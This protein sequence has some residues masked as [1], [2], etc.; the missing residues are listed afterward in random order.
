MNI[1]LIGMP[2][3]G[4]SF[5]GKKIALKLGY[6][7]VDIDEIIEKENGMS[8]QKLLDK[9][10]KEKFIEL[11]G[12]AVLNLE[13]EEKIISP[14]GSVIYSN[15]AM[16]F[17][18]KNSKIF[19]LKDYME[20][21]KKRVH[22]FNSRGIVGLKEKSFDELFLEREKLYEKYA[23]FIIFVGDFNEKRIVGEI[24]KKAEMKIN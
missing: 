10:G 15:E 9:V 20:K 24:L 12:K 22:N 1:T 3:V 4:K 23:D 17:L 5:I 2:G 8:I 6:E 14:G 13:G 11:E 18:K 21:I 16:K 19:Y 7:F